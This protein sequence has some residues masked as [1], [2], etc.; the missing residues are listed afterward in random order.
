M[1]YKDITKLSTD[2]SVNI[3][4]TVYKCNL[5]V[6]HWIQSNFMRNIAWYMTKNRMCPIDENEHFC[7]LC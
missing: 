4:T 6:L 1:V 2:I 7:M 3:N 5:Y